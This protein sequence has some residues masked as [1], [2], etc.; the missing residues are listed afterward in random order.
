[1]EECDL[2]RPVNAAYI[3]YQKTYAFKAVDKKKTWRFVFKG[4]NRSDNLIS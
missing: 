2:D 1:L 4:S 3:E